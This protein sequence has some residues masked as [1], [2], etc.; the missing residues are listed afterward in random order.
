MTPL[1]PGAAAGDDGHQIAVVH[2]RGAGVVHQD[3]ERRP[4]RLAARVDLDRRDADPL[5]EDGGRGGRHAPR[6]RPAD[7]H[8]VAEHGAEADQLAFVED[9]DQHH[10]VVDVADRAAALVGVALQDDV[11]G[12]EL[13]RLLGQH[14][15]D[16]GAE[17][18]DDHPALRVGD[19]RELVVLL[20]DDRGHRRSEEHRVHLVACVAQGVLDQIEGDRI[21]RMERTGRDGGTGLDA[22]GGT[23]RRGGVGGA[24]PGARDGAGGGSGVARRGVNRHRGTRALRSGCGSPRVSG[25]SSVGV[26]RRFTTGR[27]SRLAAAVRVTGEFLTRRQVAVRG[28]QPLRVE[29]G[30]F[31]HLRLEDA[32]E[33]RLVRLQEIVEGN[34]SVRGGELSHVSSPDCDAD[35]TSAP[36]R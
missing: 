14:L 7:V 31:S 18:S 28:W 35:R 3:G 10:P 12:L 15:R 17:L 32:V 19:H 24:D 22:R 30:G 25:P 33:T 6:H 34:V 29:S 20:A 8:H 36:A 26:Q 23:R 1:L 2:L 21:E 11:P 27:E 9:G 13:E 16:V 5:A 4:V